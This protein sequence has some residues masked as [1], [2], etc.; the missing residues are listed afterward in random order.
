MPVTSSSVPP[1][2]RNTSKSSA[3]SGSTTHSLPRALTS[4]PTANAIAISSLLPNL[5]KPARLARPGDESRVAGARDA[6]V[7]QLSFLLD[8]ILAQLR[9]C[10]FTQH[11]RGREIVIRGVNHEDTLELKSFGT[12]HGAEADHRRLRKLLSAQTMPRHARTFKP[13]LDHVQQ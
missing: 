6:D 3:D 7:E 8:E 5:Q 9:V 13:R 1:S 12:V 10:L 4:E 11:C 2:G